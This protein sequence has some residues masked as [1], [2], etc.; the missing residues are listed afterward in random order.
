MT[1]IALPG[2]ENLARRIF[3]IVFLL[4]FTYGTYLGL[5][6]ILLE[7]AVSR[8]ANAYYV[9]NVE[10]YRFASMGL[11]W[12]PLP[13]TLQ[14][15]IIA[16]AKFW[17]PLATQGIGAAFISAVFGAWSS[18]ILIQTYQRMRVQEVWAIV[19][20]LLSA[21]NPYIFFYG[22]NGMSE[23]I[24]YSF[25]VL[26]VCKLTLWMKYGAT[27]SLVSIAIGFVGLFLTRYESIPFASAIGMG[28]A[29]HILFSDNEKMYYIRG[30]RTET[31]RY[32]EGTLMLIFAPI[33]YTFLSW[34]MY[35]LVIT[36]NPIYFLNSAYSNLA[37]SAHYSPFNGIVEA[38]SFLWARTWPF[39]I[40]V[41]TIIAIRLFSGTLL[42]VDTFIFLSC[43]L[44]LTVFQFVMLL[45][46]S[47]AG[48]V[49]YMSYPLLV[50]FAWLPYELSPA[51]NSLLPD[52]K[53]TAKV[54]LL[55]AMVFLV[56]WFGTA[57]NSN[58]TFR[59]DTL[60]TVPEGSQQVADYINERLSDKRILMDAY[61]AYYVFMNIYFPDNI[62]ISSSE[63]FNE[64]L[65]DPA[66]HG[67][68]YILVPDSGRFGD[69]DAVNVAYH[70]L[71]DSGAYWCTE[72]VALGEFKLF[73]V[74]DRVWGDEND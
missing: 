56:I 49:R 59:V 73:R 71:F 68:D 55:A 25:T 9:L 14:L 29:A 72:E 54:I 26:I 41:M 40:L 6:N 7:D 13:S 42:K 24:S 67:I 66:A 53:K 35:N 34:M 11:V 37:F 62:V 44:V 21:L 4:E 2:R 45:N 30:K 70:S 32:L 27:S 58:E 57:M 38:F 52:T 33:A 16:L 39:L 12:N 18:S 48:H 50:C 28:I 31:W 19:F 63:N 17:K 22:A 15:P 8:T 43:A 1:S 5:N 46:G 20:T 23:I 60:L 65:A 10:P 3:F 51:E 64:S 61:R 47:S 74:T 69:L 36:G